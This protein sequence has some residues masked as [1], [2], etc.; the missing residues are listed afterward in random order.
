MM[1]YCRTSLS[2]CD[3]VVTHCHVLC[4][5]DSVDRPLAYA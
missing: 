5:F 1:G 3:V 2:Y 4:C